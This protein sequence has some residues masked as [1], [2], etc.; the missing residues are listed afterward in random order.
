MAEKTAAVKRDIL[1]SLIQRYGHKEPKILI[2]KAKERGLYHL[3]QDDKE[4]YVLME[5]FAEYHNLPFGFM[6]PPKE[7]VHIIDQIVKEPVD[8]NVDTFLDSLLNERALTV[9]RLIAIDKL[10]KTYKNE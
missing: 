7:A 8:P 4:I 5:K 10:I 6:Q 9:K 2:A 1:M 3:S